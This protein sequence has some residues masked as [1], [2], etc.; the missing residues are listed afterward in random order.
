MLSV[1][2]GPLYTSWN[3]HVSIYVCMCFGTGQETSLEF[4][5]E[6]FSQVFGPMWI[7][8]WG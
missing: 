3:T 5:L 8:F 2:S 6:S 1:K 4:N 7:K